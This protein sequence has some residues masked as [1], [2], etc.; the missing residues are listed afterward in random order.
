MFNKI[1]KIAPL[2]FILLMI[3]STVSEA[4][5]GT[6][7]V[8]DSV[9][10]TDTRTG[11]G[12]NPNNAF[13]LCCASSG[14]DAQYE[15]QVRLPT[16]CNEKVCPKGE[17]GMI[18]TCDPFSIFKFSYCVPT[19]ALPPPAVT[20]ITYTQQDINDSATQNSDGT[21]TVSCSSHYTVKYGCTECR[22]VLR[23]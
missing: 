12:S 11:T 17:K 21:F 9:S 15:A 16:S 14:G 13:S 3:L 10:I 20:E 23:H 18:Q 8:S 1:S 5:E 22:S 4:A 6:C 2:S 19:S 7:G